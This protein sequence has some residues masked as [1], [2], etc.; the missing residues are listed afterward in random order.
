L[1]DPVGLAY[2]MAAAV[3]VNVSGLAV[4]RAFLAEGDFAVEVAGT[5][6]PARLS[7]QPF[8]DP[9]RERMRG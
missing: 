6:V 2:P 9:R 3:S 4:N 8:Y 5:R 7:L 1:A